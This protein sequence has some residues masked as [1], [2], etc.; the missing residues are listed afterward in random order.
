MLVSRAVAEGGTGQ[1]L[2]L[3]LIFRFPIFHPLLV[4]A[5]SSRVSAMSVALSTFR[6]YFR[7]T[8][9]CCAL[10]DWACLEGSGYNRSDRVL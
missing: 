6:R 2:T 10:Y 5:R 7:S 3:K 4:P 8:G 1:F 9:K